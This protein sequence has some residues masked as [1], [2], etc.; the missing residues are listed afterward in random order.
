MR[1]SAAA[2][3][4]PLGRNGWGPSALSWL[5]IAAPFLLFLYLL[6]SFGSLPRN[7]YWGDFDDILS[8]S[9]HIVADPLR[10]IEARSNEHFIGLNLP[11]WLLNIEWTRGDNRGL[12]LVSWLEL[13]ALFALLYRRLPP[14]VRRDPWRRAAHAAPIAALV[15]TPAAAHNW[16]LGFSGNQWFLANLLAVAT[17]DALCPRRGT[18]SRRSIW[19]LWF[20]LAA[21]THSTFLALVPILLLGAALIRSNVPRVRLTWALTAVGAAIVFLA[22]YS[23]PQRHPRP[24]TSPLK[25]VSFLCEYLGAALTER[26]PLTLLIGALGLVLFTALGVSFLVR[27]RNQAAAASFFWPFLALF[28]VGTGA[29]TAVA[30]GGFGEAYGATQS[31]YASLPALF[32]IG[33]VMT[34][35]ELAAER[36]T[37]GRSRRLRTATLAV[38]VVLG[39]GSNYVLGARRL[40][41][42]YVK[43]AD[44]RVAAL[45]I[46]WNLWDRPLMSPLVHLV[47]ER[48][49]SFFVRERHIPFDVP[50]EG[51]RGATIADLPDPGSSPGWRIRP[52]AAVPVTNRYVR[53]SG[54]LSR[55]VDGAAR[56][57]FLDE[58]HAVRGAAV[59]QPP[60]GP[61][62]LAPLAQALTPEPAIRWLGYVERSALDRTDPYL[63]RDDVTAL[64]PL[65]WTE[66][67]VEG[68]TADPA[69][70]LAS[71]ER[72]E[73]E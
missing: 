52:I 32:W 47:S 54:V 61:F 20:L 55:P 37:N 45:A 49:R 2:P 8:D 51:P 25:L 71:S 48:T 5:L 50:I 26:P 46:R 19:I 69:A 1:E 41:R 33:V 30:R 13:V 40:H 68:M 59:L 35:I 27:R 17:L 43:L 66:R 53:L 6:P 67:P 60:R 21:V 11:V 58:A 73:T 7:D 23:R 3:A 28:P 72:G 36:S 63:V 34:W 15:A 42:E 65:T 14:E 18:E 64:V 9:G 56:L 38:V 10:W 70:A 57:L 4:E 44:S 12:A 24:E 29:L 62:W 31:R 16:F 39:L 22:A